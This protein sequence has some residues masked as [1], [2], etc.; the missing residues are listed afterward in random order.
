MILKNKNKIMNNFLK[1]IWDRLQR[2]ELNLKCRRNRSKMINQCNII[3][4]LVWMKKEARGM[5][6]EKVIKNMIKDTVLTEVEAEVAGAE[7]GV[8]ACEEE[9]VIEVGEEVGII[10]DTIS[11]EA[12]EE[13][14]ITLMA[15]EVEEVGTEAVAAIIIEEA[16][17]KATT[18][19]VKKMD[20]KKLKEVIIKTIMHKP[21]K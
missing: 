20:M 7:A 21:I 12:G 19:V 8:E 16:T 9:V 2:K 1:I 4:K 11:E 3:M 18:K 15:T 5:K 17:T 13:D 14:I 6:K 10:E